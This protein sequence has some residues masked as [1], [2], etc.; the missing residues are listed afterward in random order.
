MKIATCTGLFLVL[1]LAAG[2]WGGA[3][4][5][6]AQAGPDSTQDAAD[7]SRTDTSLPWEEEDPDQ[8]EAAERTDAQSPSDSSNHAGREGRLDT[9]QIAPPQR[10]GEV[11][12]T[13]ASRHVPVESPASLP[14]SAHLLPDSPRRGGA[15]RPP[16]GEAQ[17]WTIPSPSADTSLGGPRISLQPERFPPAVHDTIE[18]L[19]V[20][21]ADL[22][23]LLRGIGQQFGVNLLVEQGIQKTATVQLSQISVLDALQVLCQEHGLSLLQT[24]PV[25]RIREPPKPPPEPPKIAYDEGRVTLDLSGDKLSVVAEELTRK[26]DANFVLS[27]GVKGT[28]SGFLQDVPLEEG[29]STLLDNNG[30]LL[31]Q[32]EEIYV[33]DRKMQRSSDGSSGRGNRSMWV[34]ADGNAVDLEVSQAPISDVLRE[35][36]SQMN[37]NLVTYKV[38]QGRISATVQDMNADQVF[39]LLFRSTNVTYR[40]RDSTYF[41]GA[42]KTSSIATTEVVSLDHV[43]A[44][45]VPEMLPQSLKQK[46]TIKVIPEQNG[47]MLTG[48][49]NAIDQLRSAVEAVDQPTPLILMEALVVDFTT[50]DLFELGIEFGQN[51]QRSEQAERKGYTFDEDGFRLEGED[52]KLNQYLKEL[53]PL[54]SNFGIQNIGELPDDFFFKLQALSREGKVDIRSRPQVAALSGHTASIEIGQTQYFILRKET[55]VRS[56]EG[57]AVIQETERFEKIEANVSLKITPWVT[58]SGEVTTKIRPEFSQP[59]GEFNAETP[60]TINR[61]TLESTVR[62]KEGETIIL[63]GL[64]REEKTVEHNKIPILGSIPLLGRLFRSK[65]TNTE[66]SELVIYL[67][68]HVFYGS[69]NEAERWKQLREEMDLRP[70]RKKE[71]N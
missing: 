20:R 37:L 47:L 53:I 12:S 10:S 68:P 61:R 50:T 60:P 48:A 29:L 71:E 19:S 63:G 65:S 51:A 21:E 70:P 38:P 26:T 25:F 62:L 67:T 30:Y 2:L 49:N 33:I 43:K 31:R 16:G 7:T 8:E 39:D 9:L 15:R 55:P 54:T 59:V 36:S 23:N 3:A 28:I 42:R 41:V 6:W 17:R 14:D 11:G 44:A 69:E 5:C 45:R 35:V 32:R 13:R 52:Q 34:N 40:Q 58:S 64:I 4:P 1:L 24:G 46:A 18:T 22:R 27:D 66:K 57:G 56:P